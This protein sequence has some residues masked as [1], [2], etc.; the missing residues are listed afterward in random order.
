MWVMWIIKF[1]RYDERQDG[2]EKRIFF[3]HIHHLLTDIYQI[4]KVYILTE[5]MQVEMKKKYIYINWQIKNRKKEENN[6][7]ICTIIQFF[8]FLLQNAEKDEN[9]NWCLPVHGSWHNAQH[10]K[11]KISSCE[12]GVTT[13]VIRWRHLIQ[14]TN[15]QFV[16]SIYFILY[17]SYILSLE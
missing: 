8:Q 13:R 2:K 5:T 3:V 10:L 6:N 11:E 1:C 4:S 12:R 14:K 17:R 7:N 15:A 16:V 9:L